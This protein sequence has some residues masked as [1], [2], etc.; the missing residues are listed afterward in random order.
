[1]ANVPAEPLEK[2]VADRL[3][4]LGRQDRTIDHLVKEAMSD[5]TE[6]LGNL[7]KCREDRNAHRLRVQDRIDALVEGLAG[8]RTGLK[9]ISKKLVELEEQTEQL[10]EEILGLD[11]E[12]G[13]AK[14]KAVSA[15]SMTKSLT[16]FGDLYHGATPEE[17][18]ELIRLQ[19]NRVVWSPKQIRLALLGS[20][21]SVAGV[22]PEVTVGSGGGNRTPDTRIMI[23]LL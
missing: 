6:L 3:M 12:I 15:R 2:V 10:D 1:M 8:R 7:T 19:L 14:E 23:P 16:T 5:M 20:T 11:Q 17:R 18:R 13:A 22:Q 9:S 21:K 4:E